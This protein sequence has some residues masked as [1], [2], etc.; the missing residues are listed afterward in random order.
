[1][2]NIHIMDIYEYRSINYGEFSKEHA[3]GKSASHNLIQVPI[4]ELKTIH[5]PLDPLYGSLGTLLRQV[6]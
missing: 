2:V 6:T 3:L 5:I 1:M 4:F